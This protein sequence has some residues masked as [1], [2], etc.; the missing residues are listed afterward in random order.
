MSGLRKVR[1]FEIRARERQQA[2]EAV[3]GVTVVFMQHGLNICNYF[4]LHYGTDYA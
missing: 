2:K 4:I 1:E 3:H